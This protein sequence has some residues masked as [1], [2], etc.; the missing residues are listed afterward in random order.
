MYLII[1]KL[2]EILETVIEVSLLIFQGK[3]FA[4]YY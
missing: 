2:K 4:E 3:E 1:N